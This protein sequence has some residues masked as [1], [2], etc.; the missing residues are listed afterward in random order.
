MAELW[1]LDRAIVP[2]GVCYCLFYWDL[3]VDPLCL[4]YKT[5]LLAIVAL[6]GSVVLARIDLLDP[7]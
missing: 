4:M 1:D 3:L 6:L 5:A 2:E 7:P